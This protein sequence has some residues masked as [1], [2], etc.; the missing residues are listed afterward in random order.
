MAGSRGCR[1]RG[2]GVAGGA[3]AAASRHSE[4]E[5]N[6]YQLMYINGNI[7][8]LPQ[9]QSIVHVQIATR[10]TRLRAQPAR[11]SRRVSM[12]SRCQRASDPDRAR[13]AVYRAAS[14]Q[15]HGMARAATS[16]SAFPF[17]RA[18]PNDFFHCARCSSRVASLL[19]R[20]VQQ[21]RLVSLDN[22]R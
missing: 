9:L 3:A 21:P 19:K 16:S 14:S 1:E 13:L 8:D 2:V 4:D 20:G 5:T 7:S 11:S 12:Q 15:R 18:A 6:E 10:W 22:P 17:G